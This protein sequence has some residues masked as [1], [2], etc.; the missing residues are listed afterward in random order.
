[1]SETD[2]V[3]AP[4]TAGRL[5]RE[6]RQAQ[7]LHI[8]ALAST[9]KVTPR[10]LELLEADRLD[11]LPDATFTRALAQTVCRTLKIDAAP[12]LALLPR[13]DAH[14]LGD[15]GS[16]LNEPFRSRPA[17]PMGE[18]DAPWLRP[19][20]WG[21]AALLVVAGIVYALPAGWLPAPPWRH[22]ASASSSA[23][24]VAPRPSSSASAMLASVAASDI[25]TGAAASA[26]AADASSPSSTEAAATFASDAAAT[27]SPSAASAADANGAAD[28]SADREEGALVL[29]VTSDSWIEVVDAEGKSLLARTVR[30]GESVALEGAVPLRL[31][32]GNA[33]AT[34]VTF[35]GQPVAL[36]P[37]THENLAR[38]ELR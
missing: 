28:S 4:P 17:G 1:M 9:I 31:R 35:R 19:A 21:P 27:P 8:A 2:S 10:K 33:P 7:G 18:D 32:I 23:S 29:H 11:E 15:V 36:A 38:L 37:Y 12:V 6:A 3:A 20:V 34:A 30:P 14:R 24:G 16:G 22:V 5:L 13:P 25:A 26:P